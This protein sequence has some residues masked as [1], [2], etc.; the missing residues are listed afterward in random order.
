MSTRVQP[1][2]DGGQVYPQPVGSPKSG[3]TT[4]DLFAGQIAAAFVSFNGSLSA[5]TIADQAYKQADALIKRGK[6]P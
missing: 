5:D 3:M 4:R 2:D 6:L 1:I